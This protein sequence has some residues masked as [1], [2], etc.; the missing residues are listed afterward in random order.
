M[1]KKH[2]KRRLPLTE[3]IAETEKLDQ[4]E[5]VK[6]TISLLRMLYLKIHIAMRDEGYVNPSTFLSHLIREHMPK[7]K[8][9]GTEAHGTPLPPV[10]EGERKV[11]FE[12][13]GNPF[14]GGMAAL[15]AGCA[16]HAML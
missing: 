13:Q 11:G 4:H 1:K 14:L 7:P 9:G 6:L 2:P 8:N 12:K 5:S 15:L 16:V 3:E 10:P